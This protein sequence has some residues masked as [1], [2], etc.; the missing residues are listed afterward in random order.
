MKLNDLTKKSED[1]RIE[2]FDYGSISDEQKRALNE[3]ANF[4]SIKHPDIAQTIRNKF[5]L[6][7][8]KK[9]KMETSN[10]LQL[11]K[12][13]NINW[14]LQGFTLT[15]DE[16]EEEIQYPIVSITEDIRELERLLL[17]I[18]KKY[19]LEDK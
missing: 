4:L 16:K 7:E 18:V 19:G 11:C 9:V 15:R 14:S 10:F 13:A 1:K 3:C 12:E 2:M 6:V 8:P 5:Y 17:F